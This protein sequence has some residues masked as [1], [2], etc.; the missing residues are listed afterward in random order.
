MIRKVCATAEILDDI[1]EEGGDTKRLFPDN[2]IYSNTDD[3]RDDCVKNGVEHRGNQGTAEYQL[4]AL[5]EFI[6][7][8]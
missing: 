2:R 6:D 3:L 5:C 8:V 1:E 4:G 7:K